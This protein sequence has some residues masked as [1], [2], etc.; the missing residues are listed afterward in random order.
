MGKANHKLQLRIKVPD[1]KHMDYFQ[2]AVNIA[3]G[4]RVASNQPVISLERL[5]LNAIIT[6]AN[7]I[8]QEYAAAMARQAAAQQ[9]PLSEEEKAP[10][11]N[12]DQIN[13]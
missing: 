11:D 8:H 1:Q 7:Q 13:G 6:G 3:N 5:C 9:S 4:V 10:L 2:A 12:E